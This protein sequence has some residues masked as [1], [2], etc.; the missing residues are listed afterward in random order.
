MLR[1][2]TF[3]Q[4]VP[5]AALLKNFR[6]TFPGSPLAMRHLEA[7]SLLSRAAI[8]IAADAALKMADRREQRV[9][10]TQWRQG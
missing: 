10:T 9:V 6:N 3:R 7:F 8:D 1:P 5:Q 4:D 2:M